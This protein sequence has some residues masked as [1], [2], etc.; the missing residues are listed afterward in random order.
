MGSLSLGFCVA[1]QK[2]L[3]PASLNDIAK[4][5]NQLDFPA[6]SSVW[7]KIFGGKSAV[8]TTYLPLLTDSYVDRY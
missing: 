6:I 3:D 4:H 8:L 1:G 2:I 7:R 5:L